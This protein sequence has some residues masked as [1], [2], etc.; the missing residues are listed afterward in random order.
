MRIQYARASNKLL[1]KVKF[2]RLDVTVN[3]PDPIAER[4][5]VEGYP[6]IKF[7]PP[8]KK[9]DKV[10]I[11][12]KGNNEVDDIV[13][14]ATRERT[15]VLEGEE[16]ALKDEDVIILENSNFNTFKN[17]K[18]AWFVEFYAP[19]CGH[20]KSLA[21]IYRKVATGLKDKGVKVAKVNVVD[22]ERTTKVMEKYKD[23]IKGY[24]TVFFFP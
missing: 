2:G 3:H 11:E 4:V 13:E 8:G 9:E 17:S 7:W 20:C 18:E 10:Y 19:W 23:S 6:N 5:K 22:S 14:W 15:R 1:G 21:P 12:F 16:A 24:P